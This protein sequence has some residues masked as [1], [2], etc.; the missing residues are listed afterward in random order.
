M[1]HF[2]FFTTRWMARCAALLVAGAFLFVVSGE[3]LYPHS[4]P[5]THVREWAGIVLLIATIIA[6]LLAWKWELPGA[7]ASLATLAVFVPTA[8]GRHYSVVAAIAIPGILFV[9]DWTLRHHA[10]NADLRGLT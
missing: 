4:G 10:K 2:I 8:G 5:P 7:L 1:S 3:F 6:A 9:L